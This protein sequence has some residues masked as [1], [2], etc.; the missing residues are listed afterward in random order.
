LESNN[1]VL[2]FDL[3]G[4]YAHFRK[5]YTTASQ[6][7]YGIPP[8]TTLGGMI[9]G[10]LG[11]ERDSYYPLFQEGN[12]IFSLALMKPIKK[13]K[14]NLNL[15]KTKDETL[16]LIDPTKTPPKRIERIQVPFEMV[17][18]PHY[19]VFT[20]F[21]DNRKFEELESYL[22]E[23][24]SVY[25]P[26]LGISE[27]LGDFKFI[28]KAEME[29]REGKANI[30]SI[31]GDTDQVIIEYDKKYVRERVPGFFSQERVP[32]DYIDLIYEPDGKSIQV[33]DSDY[34]RVGD[35]NII[36]F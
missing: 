33:E 15:L 30:D 34:W 31:I 10:I 36:F 4:D 35:Q 12:S 2:V 26:Y 16:G 27:L 17:K 20:W 5:T 32:T 6:L 28:G 9:A 25:T 13:Q 19:R 1:E 29:K 21:S 11:L 8:R 18:D 7:T 24:K 23:H 22:K 14:I 3:M